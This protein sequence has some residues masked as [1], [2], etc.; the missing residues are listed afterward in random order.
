MK[1]IS[2]VLLKIRLSTQ[3]G[4]KF[5]QAWNTVFLYYYPAEFH[6]IYIPTVN[7]EKIYLH[8][9]HFI[10]RFTYSTLPIIIILCRIYE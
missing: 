6:E 7:T 10:S 3:Y 9:M 8:Y 4:P 1:N 5:E 2:N